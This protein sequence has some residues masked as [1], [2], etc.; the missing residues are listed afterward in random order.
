M[1]TYSKNTTQKIG[2]GNTINVN[3]A[4]AG[5]TIVFTNTSKQYAKVILT[6]SL[7]QVSGGGGSSANLSVSVG[8]V[9]VASCGTSGAG[10]NATLNNLTQLELLVP[11]SAALAVSLA[12]ASATAT[13]SVKGAYVAFENTP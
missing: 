3:L 7:S 9:V 6:G 10:Q 5:T 2:G 4:A 12:L 13:S 8:G 1:A 11:P